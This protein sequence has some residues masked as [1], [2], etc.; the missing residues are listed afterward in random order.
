MVGLLQFFPKRDGSYR[1]CVDYRALNAV[2]KKDAYPIPYVSVILDR[3][4]DARYIS[5]L[6]VKSAFWQ[7][8][9]KESSREYTAFT[10][11]GRGLYYFKR[12]P[13]GL[14]NSPATWQRLLDT[15]LGADLEPNV[16]VYLDDIVVISSDFDTH[17]KILSKVFDRLFAAGLTLSKDDVSFAD[18]P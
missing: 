4:R 10:V 8:S 7:V 17:L 12:M 13:F 14:T 3:L 9:V 11:P 18:L 5:T 15:V 1:F 2:T 6:D 16:L